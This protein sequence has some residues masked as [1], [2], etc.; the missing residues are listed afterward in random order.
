MIRS[1]MV[2]TDG[3]PCGKVALDYARYWADRM[4]LCVTVLFV[5]DLRL[6]QGPLMTGY[7]GPVGMA[8][9]AAYPA[10]YEDLVRSVKQQADR[11][12]AEARDVFKDSSLKVDYQVREGI[13]RDVILEMART[14]DLLCLGRQGEH[15]EWEDGELG[16][17][18]QKV[19]HRSQR[20]VLVTPN[21]FHPLS[22]LLVAYDASSYANRA[23]RVAC[24]L[25]SSIE[26][27]MTV[28]TVAP[29]ERERQ[30]FEAVLDEARKLAAPYD[31]VASEFVLLVGEEEETLVTEQADERQCD[32]IV[33]GAY[34]ESR[35]RE[36][37]L[38]STTAGVLA[39]SA[40]PVLLV[41]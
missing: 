25:A 35:I 1:M 13:V 22:R 5:E 9:S 40:L 36:W 11:V 41:R 14:V 16:S 8:P 12:M 27:P 19:L 20:P 30:R 2:C 3:S 28:V 21:V 39:R 26:L 18:V 31:K 10:F 17:T 15:G 4:K 7:Y 23:L 38:G 6:T 29:D 34:G 24:D 32:L 33:M 37:L